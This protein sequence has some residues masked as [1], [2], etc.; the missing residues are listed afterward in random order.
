MD[1]LQK[2]QSTTTIV[3]VV[4]KSSETTAVSKNTGQI[5]A[6]KQ[7]NVYFFQYC[8]IRMQNLLFECTS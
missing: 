5:E 8:Q 4:Q 3:A 7:P 2:L 1:Q 6:E